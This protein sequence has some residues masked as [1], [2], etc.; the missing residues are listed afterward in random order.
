MHR[1]ALAAKIMSV[2]FDSV[3]NQV[4]QIINHIKSRPLNSHLFGVL[5]CQEMVS[6]HEQLLLHTEVRWL[7]RG[8]VLQ[9]LYELRGKV[10]LCLAEI[11]SDL[12][13]HLDDTMWL[14]S[15]S[16][17][18][19]IFDHLNSL[20]LSLQSS[21]THILLLADRVNAFTQTLDLWRG[22]ISHQEL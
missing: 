20:N 19:H 16:Y 14:T 7:S 5:P 9:R 8:R 22:R 18:V 15:L 3:L 12:A 4:V 17:L 2:L 1:E 11:K 13:K 10:K 6:G 21:E